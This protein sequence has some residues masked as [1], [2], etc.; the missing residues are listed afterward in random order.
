M[1]SIDAGIFFSARLRRASFF[2]L[3]TFFVKT[4][5]CFLRPSEIEDDFMIDRAPPYAGFFKFLR[6]FFQPGYKHL[7][8]EKASNI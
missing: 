4:V 2:D 3:D 7:S 5:L 6:A 1:L 8:R